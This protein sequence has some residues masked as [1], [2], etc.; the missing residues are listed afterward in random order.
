[1]HA[2]RATLQSV[3]ESMDWPE[4]AA[5]SLVA[6]AHVIEYGRGTTIFHAGEPADIVYFL[7]EGEAKLY[8]GSADGDR[9]LVTIAR[10][11]ELLGLL[12][13]SSAGGKRRLRRSCS[14]R[15]PSPSA[16]LPC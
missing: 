8:Y 1:M 12:D 15:R 2:A 5:A 7:L 4:E 6:C 14:R 13:L 10:D 16:S 3:L 11:C 9:L